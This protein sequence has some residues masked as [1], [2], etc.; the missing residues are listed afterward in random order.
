MSRI[1]WQ[2]PETARGER[3]DRWLAGQLPDLTRS[4]VQK[5]I[6]DGRVQVDGVVAAKG[7]VKLRGT[8]HVSVALPEPRPP[9]P[10]PEPLPLDVLY[11]DEDV[12]VVNKPPGL[13]VHPAPGH[14]GGTLVN[15]L[16]ARYPDL[17]VRDQSDR[18]GIVHRLDRD[19]SGVLIVAR[20]A[21][22]RRFLQRQFSR[23]EVEKFYLAAVHGRPSSDHGL[24]DAPLGRD[25]RDRKKFAVVPGGRPALTEFTVRELFPEYT[26]LEVRLITGRT[27]QIR[28]HLASIGTPIVNDTVYGRRRP[29]PG[30]PSQR[31][32]L[33][34]WR[35]R[36]RLPSGAIHTFEAPL[37]P[38]LEATLAFWRQQVDVRR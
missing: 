30:L 8:E 1:T 35:L 22:A 17:A 24:I 7:G 13:V 33:H 9:T 26:L 16:L 11:E 4:A 32:F 36:L 15:A 19:T 37:A 29:V 31:Q 6:T 10:Q 34:A 18:P 21:E 27:H 12:I 25:P 5:L 3:L 38:D 20:H 28:V 14:E 2:V 23:R